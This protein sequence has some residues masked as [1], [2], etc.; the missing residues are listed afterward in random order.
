MINFHHGVRG[1]LS[2]DRCFN[3]SVET[4]PFAAVIAG[5]FLPMVELVAGALVTGAFAEGRIDAAEPVELRRSPAGWQLWRNGQRFQIHGVGGSSH[6]SLLKQAGGNS[7]RTWSTDDLD[8]LLGQAQQHGL[9]VCVGLWLGHERHGFNYSDDAAVMQQLESCLE[10]VRKYKDHPAVL[11]WS[12][13][14]E[15]EGD[16]K[17]P[18]IWY[19]ID[20][21]ARE[22]KRLDPNHPTMTVIA[23]LGEN[24]VQRLHRLCPNIDIV[25]INSYAGVATVAQ[26]YRRAGGIKP[27]IITE[28]GPRGP[29]EVEKTAWG[30][31]LEASSTVKARQ[32]AAGHREAVASQPSLCLGSYSFLWGHKQETTATWFGML[33]PDGRRLGAV[34]AMSAAWRETPVEDRCPEI[35][36]LQ[37]VNATAVNP[38][39]VAPGDALRFELD[40]ADPE[41]HTLRYQWVLRHD[42]VTI[43]VGGDAQAKESDLPDAVKVSVDGAQAVVTAP[44]GGGGYRLFAY[45]TDPHGGAAVANVPF[46]VDAPIERKPAAKANLPFAV[47]A[48]GQPQ[49]IFIPSGYMGNS[50]SVRMNLDSTKD[51]KQGPTCL[52]ATYEAGDQW[53]G[54]LWQS[55]P[56]DWTGERPGGLDFAG[57]KAV[58][59]WARGESG[60]E[61]VTFLVGAIT[62]DKPYVD[63]DRVELKDIELTK[64]WQ[65]LRIPLAGRDLSRIKT[66][67][68]WSLAGQGRP[69]KFYLDDIRYVVE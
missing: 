27:Y 47:Y 50:K 34:D 20:H 23:E 9:A 68:G 6:L 59:F 48:D 56:Q 37:L 1:R 51:P 12:I 17:N 24:K 4:A 25:G 57:A 18:A 55:P 45:V 38:G 43:G 63:S 66:A 7:I 2:H 65:R 39:K 53:G 11:M 15:A 26:R 44:S 61:R 14:N 33:L 16:G 42:S 28:H 69:V 35:T 5:L 13:G 36:R 31:P 19:A 10:A 54:V 49:R 60:G 67:F 52:E 62:G 40:A 3:R 32:Y 22:I 30:A 58:E 41:G 46:F 8:S 64:K 21:I 29:W